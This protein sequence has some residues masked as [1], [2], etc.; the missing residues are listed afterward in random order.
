[1]EEENKNSMESLNGADDNF[2][3]LKDKAERIND[4]YKELFEP[5]EARDSIEQKIASLYKRLFEGSEGKLSIE[6][7]VDELFNNAKKDYEEFQKHF[8]AIS[9]FNGYL[10]IGDNSNLP[11]EKQINNLYSKLFEGTDDDDS[12]EVQFNN[13]L[14]QL[15]EQLENI[16]IKVDSFSLAYEKVFIDTKD[17]SGKVVIPS[18]INA[19]QEQ[20]KELNSLIEEANKKLYAL[21]DSS[22]H[23]AFAKRANEYTDEFKKLEKRTHNLTWAVIGDIVLFGLVQLYLLYHGKDFNYHLLIYQFSIAGALIFAIWMYNRNQKIAKKLA[24]EYHHKAA[25]AEAMT[26]YRQLYELEHEDKEYMELFNSLKDQLNVNPSKS[27]DKFLNLKSPQEEL[28]ESLKKL[29]PD[30]INQLSD[31]I[32]PK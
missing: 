17:E 23:N 18:L 12:L 7:E 21:T 24:E 31:L 26:G 10:F 5:T 15:E 1:M 3:D 28:S 25:I 2:L 9:R 20:K 32:K 13:L 16:K 6:I 14:E 11:L 19:I 22:L 30:A 29:G 27:I 8:D 4:F